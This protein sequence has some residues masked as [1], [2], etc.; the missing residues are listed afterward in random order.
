MP[1]AYTCSVCGEQGHSSS[2]CKSLGIPPNGF[3]T[4]GGRG[5]QHSHDDEDKCLQLSS[6]N[7]WDYYSIYN[8]KLV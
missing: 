2:S 1:K 8:L 7:D 3:Y 6:Y 5:A 4:G